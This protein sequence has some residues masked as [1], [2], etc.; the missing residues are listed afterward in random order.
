MRLY[1]VFL[2]FT[3]FSCFTC[4][5]QKR[6][7]TVSSVIS[8]SDV[9]S[10]NQKIKIDLFDQVAEEKGISFKFVDIPNAR[11]DSEFLKGNIDIQI[12]FL[13]FMDYSHDSEDFL[14]SLPLAIEQ[15][16]IMARELNKSL[17]SMS[18]SVGT[19]R[20]DKLPTF[21]LQSV[22]HYKYESI[23]LSSLA[24][25]FI[26]RRLDGIVISSL[27]IED[28]IFDDIETNT[29]TLILYRLPME[30]IVAKTQSSNSHIIHS[31]NRII[32]SKDYPVI[33]V[34]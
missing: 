18:K 23:N 16:V 11:L 19:V 12:L 28:L 22:G 5:Y 25:M 24:A 3:C 2:F 13:S 20:G 34:E 7:L 4:E 33:L 14:Y 27:V 29:D 9:F 1:L 6:T 31:L 17:S 21:D 10:F 30:L 15:R 8:L 26:E 32:R